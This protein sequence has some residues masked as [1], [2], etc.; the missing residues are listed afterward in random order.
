VF[1][2]RIEHP[3]YPASKG[4]ILTHVL[5]HEITHILQRIDRHSESG[6]M[7]AAWANQDYRDMAWRPL[8]FT[9]HDIVLICLGREE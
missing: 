5:V 6:V 3:S 2:D 4:V 8:S 7:K 1:W 9:P